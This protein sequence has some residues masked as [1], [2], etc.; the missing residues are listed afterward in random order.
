MFIF[1]MQNL[2]IIAAEFTVQQQTNITIYKRT[3]ITNKENCPSH[4]VS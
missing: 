4:Q 1:K 2:Q 3:K